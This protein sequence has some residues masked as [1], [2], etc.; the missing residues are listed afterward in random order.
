MKALEVVGDPAWP[1]VILL[2]QIE[3]LAHHSGR[4]S[5]RRAMGRPRAI[6]QACFPELVKTALPFVER[7]PRDTEIPTGSRDLAWFVTS[8]P[9]D[10]QSPRG[11]PR[12]LC[13]RRHSLLQV[14]RLEKRAECVTLLLGFHTWRI[15]SPGRTRTSDQRINS[16]SLYQLSYRGTAP[17]QAAAFWKMVPV[18]SRQ[19][20]LNYFRRQRVS[21]HIA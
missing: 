14:D 4:G 12:L 19:R 1:E 11:K 20:I 15:G 17:F 8:R 2:A 3:D 16:P 6:G 21:G 9:Q 18:K 13:L 10:L 5:P 7:C